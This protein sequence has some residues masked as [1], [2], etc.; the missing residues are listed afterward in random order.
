MTVHS[1]GK[2]VSKAHLQQHL[3]VGMKME[4]VDGMVSGEDGVA[5][6]LKPNHPSGG[7]EMTGGV[8]MMNGEVGNLH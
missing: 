7:K 1:Y 5:S 6:H 4:A 2:K 3:L 8:V